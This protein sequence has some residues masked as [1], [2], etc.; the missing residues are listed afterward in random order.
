MTKEEALAKFETKMVELKGS[1]APFSEW[2]FNAGSINSIANFA[3]CWHCDLLD[4]NKKKRGVLLLHP[5]L[6]CHEVHGAIGREYFDS[7]GRP[8]GWLGFPVSDEETQGNSEDRTQKFEHGKIVWH[9]DGDYCES[10]PALTKEQRDSLDGM[11]KDWNAGA[12]DRMGPL[13]DVGHQQCRALLKRIDEE[14]M[15]NIREFDAERF[16]LV[17]FGSLKAGKSTLV[18]AFAGKQI[19]SM[20]AATETT[21][22]ANLVMAADRDHPEGVYIYDPVCAS[23]DLNGLSDDD[24]KKV[25]DQWHRDNAKHFLDYLRGIISE[26]D[27]KNYF[28]GARV[29]GIGEIEKYVTKL[30]IPDHPNMMPPVV[31]INLCGVNKIHGANIV[32]DHFI[33]VDTPGLNGTLANYDNDPF[34]RILAEKGDC[35]LFVQS[36]MSAL[37]KEAYEYIQ[38]VYECAKDASVIA[39]FNRMEAR[40]WL[41]KEPQEKHL[42]NEEQAAFEDLK[43]K[44]Q[45]ITAKIPP[46]V[47]VNTGEAWDSFAAAENLNI[48]SEKAR[49]ESGIDVLKKKICESL[50]GNE[51]KIKVANATKRMKKNIDDY[52]NEIT[53]LKNDL[54]K[55]KG[56]L[57]TECE[58]VRA[59][60]ESQ[61]CDIEKKLQNGN[62]GTNIEESMKKSI[63]GAFGKWWG[64]VDGISAKNNFNFTPGKRYETSVYDNIFEKFVDECNNDASSKLETL[65]GVNVDS[66]PVGKQSTIWCD[67]VND[68]KLNDPTSDTYALAQIIADFAKNYGNGREISLEEKLREAIKYADLKKAVGFDFNSQAGNYKATHDKKIW[69]PKDW[70]DGNPLGCECIEVFEKLKENVQVHPL[71]NGLA[72]LN[73]AGLVDKAIA[74]L[75]NEL[76]KIADQFCKTKEG[77]LAKAI[78]PIDAWIKT[79]DATSKQLDNLRLSL[80]KMQ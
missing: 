5:D 39:V 66:L 21:L 67:V 62:F 57:Q 56:D 16:L 19:S 33:L 41:K 77:E 78:E 7:N 58:K 6:G 29:G 72:S 45:K 71:G 28:A 4:A 37:T 48:N 34:A 38:K 22:R 17:V 30:D 49:E 47:S 60:I 26:A 43:K 55:E 65:T 18:N 40:F 23:P 79:L 52:R 63:G 27:F 12:Q 2:D 61:K 1:G 46:L 31:R 14:I 75:L 70:F 74:S 53:A 10:L 36:S 50:Q 59:N 69:N 8:N 64:D 25:I 9:K 24:K 44:L 20:G 80:Q 32:K 76:G 42:E 35:F 11:T 15:R 73:G 68:I 54:D 13:N 51:A 3:D